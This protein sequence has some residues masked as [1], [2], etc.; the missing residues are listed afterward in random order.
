MILQIERKMEDNLMKMSADENGNDEDAKVDYSSFSSDGE[1]PEEVD[2]ERVEECK[3]KTFCPQV[4]SS[5]IDKRSVPNNHL[6]Q[7]GEA[8]SNA[9]KAFEEQQQYQH[10]LTRFMMME[11]QAKS[12]YLRRSEAEASRL[13]Q[14]HHIHSGGNDHLQSD[15]IASA[16]FPKL[17]G[18]GASGAQQIGLTSSPNTF[19]SANFPAAYS[20]ESS[21]SSTLGGNGID[22]QQHLV[23][24]QSRSPACGSNDIQINSDTLSRMS[25]INNR[26]S[27]SNGHIK[28]PMNA[29]MVWSRAQRRKMARE[30]PK[31][32]NSEISKRLGGR[33]KHLNDQDKRPFIEEAKRL[34]ALHMKEYPDYKYKPRRKPKKFSASSGD[35]MSLHLAGSDPSNY[36]NSLPYIQFPFPLL[37]PF[38]HSA[39]VDIPQAI[40][41]ASAPSTS[42]NN[43]VNEQQHSSGLNQHRHQQSTTGNNG[44]VGSFSSR[45]TS[46]VAQFTSSLMN[47]NANHHH[48]QHNNHH[49]HHH[50]TQ[51]HQHQQHQTVT[52]LSSGSNYT[53]NNS[54]ANFNHALYQQH[55]RVLNQSYWSPS[56]ISPNR[57]QYLQQ[58]VSSQAFQQSHANPHNISAYIQQSL[59]KQ[60]TQDSQHKQQSKSSSDRSKSYLLENLIGSDDTDTTIDV[61]SR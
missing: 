57:L 12:A 8:N 14:Y 11:Q 6:D 28:R 40:L 13:Q 26:S 60:H 32:H 29:F 53:P 37:N 31:M 55:N 42:S 15:K 19:C 45:P 9:A 59:D 34:R 2:D 49:H 17:E 61:T 27:S 46:Q 38:A 43:P 44:G 50:Q 25:P 22:A 5:T 7:I 54:F 39:I 1:A 30:N 56:Q 18:A 48:S 16:G 35:L 33:W 41:T 4:A 21:T 58:N 3:S 52:N 51:E 20:I 47:D 23:S 36:Y 24:H 10:Y